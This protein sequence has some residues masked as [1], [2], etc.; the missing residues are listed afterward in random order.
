M[1]VAGWQS[2]QSS[3]GTSTPVATTLI[4]SSQILK[5]TPLEKSDTI[6]I[7]II[8][9]QNTNANQ[10]QSNHSMSRSHS[11]VGMQQDGREM[12]NNTHLQHM[13]VSRPPS[14]SSTPGKFITM[15]QC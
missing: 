5:R 11:T 10:F 13:S 12:G 9:A 14:L 7:L 4:V 15:I 6:L 8:K 2:S 3:T 1:N